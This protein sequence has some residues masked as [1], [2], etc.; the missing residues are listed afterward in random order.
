[1]KKLL[2][3]AMCLVSTSTIPKKV[4]D[5]EL[6]QW[7]NTA[8]N[9]GISVKHSVSYLDSGDN[10]VRVRSI[11]NTPVSTVKPVLSAAGKKVAK[12]ETVYRI[13]PI[14][15]GNGSYTVKTN[16]QTQTIYFYAQAAGHQK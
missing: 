12:V 13:Q 15:T 5:R 3:I 1:M 8:K 2:M 11:D 14:R 10:V 6:K 7:E 4:S 9:Y 16:G